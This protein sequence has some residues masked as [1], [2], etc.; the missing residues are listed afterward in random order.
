MGFFFYYFSCAA[1]IFTS[2]FVKNLKNLKAEK[3]YF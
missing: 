2:I 1:V 3:S